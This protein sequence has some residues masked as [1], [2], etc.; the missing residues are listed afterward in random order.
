MK[1]ILYSIVFVTLIALA[2]PKIIGFNLAA[3]LKET[4][5][6]INSSETHSGY[7]I[8]IKKLESRWFTSTAEINIEFDPYLVTGIDKFNEFVDINFTVTF[9]HGPFLKLDE[10]VLGRLAFRAELDKSLARDDVNYPD[11]E[12]LYRLDG[13]ID[14][15]GNASVVDSVPALASHDKSFKTGGWSGQVTYT[16][17]KTTLQG[18]L[19]SLSIDGNDAKVRI[20]PVK[21]EMSYEG[22]LS[23]KFSDIFLDSNIEIVFGYIRAGNEST[24][25]ITEI[26]DAAIDIHNDTNNDNELKNIRY[27]FSV[28]LIRNSEYSAQDLVFNTEIKNLD[29]DALK[30]ILFA[31]NVDASTLES[32]DFLPLY[33][34][35]PEFNISEISGVTNIGEFSGQ[36][37]TKLSEVDSLPNDLNNPAFW[38]SKLSIDSKLTIGRELASS[39]AA[40]SPNVDQNMLDTIL[41]KSSNGNYELR[42]MLKNSEALLNG[43]PL[44]IPL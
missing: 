15:S 14:L 2:V 18:E 4:V 34:A 6:L 5:E 38:L 7:S 42:F 29:R 31:S 8:R 27:D 25:D 3:S 13:H 44:P 11:G 32:A 9:L 20:K 22:S 35:S 40:A 41:I 12:S 39:L 23:R 36:M 43:I 16:A 33:Q 10:W 19:H 17:K 1:K 24:N 26:K 37:L 21:L 30:K 28:G